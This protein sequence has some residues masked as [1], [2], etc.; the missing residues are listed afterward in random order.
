V[1]NIDIQA[2]RVVDPSAV[3]V[4]TSLVTGV[5]G[6][7]AGEAG[8]EAWGRLTRLVR[9]RFDRDDPTTRA[10][11]QVDLVSGDQQMVEAVGG[12]LAQRLSDSAERDKRFSADLAAWMG[13]ASRVINIGGDGDVTNTISGD[14][15]IGGSVVQGRDFGTVNLGTPPP[16]SG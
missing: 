5:L 8:K 14:A 13:E 4:L 6:G 2:V 1:G 10:L 15:K 7:A 9:G 3:S 12:I 11:E 16:E